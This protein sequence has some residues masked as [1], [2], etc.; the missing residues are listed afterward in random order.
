MKIQILIIT[1][2]VVFFSAAGSCERNFIH[3]NSVTPDEPPTIVEMTLKENEIEQ[4]YPANGYSG[5]IGIVGNSNIGL[6][7]HLTYSPYAKTWS[8]YV[9]LR[10]WITGINVG[11]AI[12]ALYYHNEGLRYTGFTFKSMNKYGE[13]RLSDIAIP[14]II[15]RR[16]GF[17]HVVSLSENIDFKIGFGINK[18]EITSGSV[19]GIIIEPRKFIPV[20]KNNGLNI[21]M[22][23]QNGTYYYVNICAGS[24]YTLMNYYS[25]NGIIQLPP[26]IF[27]DPSLN[28][29][30][31]YAQL[32]V[33]AHNVYIPKGFKTLKYNDGNEI[34]SAVS[35][36]YGESYNIMTTLYLQ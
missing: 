31:G 36:K 12:I 10:N 8:S 29:R 3:E 7:A 1:L 34:I 2:F 23:T 6:R 18:A 9:T 19:N 16:A 20:N 32:F 30:T 28:G 27:L 25:S 35:V 22:E 5:G 33:C 4:L 14:F 17:F 21:Q 26:E 13:Y 11:D 24:C 15:G